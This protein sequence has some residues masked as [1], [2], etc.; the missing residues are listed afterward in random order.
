MT[1]ETRRD[2]SPVGGTADGKP[3]RAF[4][5]ARRTSRSDSIEVASRSRIRSAT[6]MIIAHDAR[7]APTGIRIV[8][9][10]HAQETRPSNE[11]SL[12]DDRLGWHESC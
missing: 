6:N 8:E 9:A 10:G 11:L 2:L 5:T 1:S 4:P 7:D 12:L 3:Q